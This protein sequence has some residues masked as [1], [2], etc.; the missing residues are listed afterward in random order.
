MVLLMIEIFIFATPTDSRLWFSQNCGSDVHDDA[1]RG[2]S[3]L[4]SSRGHRGHEVQ[5][6]RCAADKKRVGG[7]DY[8][9]IITIFFFFFFFF[10]F[11]K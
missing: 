9:T 2:D 11:F 8:C 5:R 6:E 7:E 10:F 4:Q 3:V 1:L